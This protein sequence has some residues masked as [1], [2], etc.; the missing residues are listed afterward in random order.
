MSPRGPRRRRWIALVVGLVVAA[1]LAVLAIG[2]VLSGVLGERGTNLDYAVANEQGRY[3]LHLKT[4]DNEIIGQVMVI[5]GKAPDT[6]ATATIS[7]NADSQG[8]TAVTIGADSQGYKWSGPALDPTTTYSIEEVKD[9]NGHGLNAT[10]LPFRL[11]QIGPGQVVSN[12]H[13]TMS[14][15][16]WL[17]TKPRGIK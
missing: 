16:D 6:P 17:A 2:Y 4:C 12:A 5:E 14:L 13:G 8:S 15:E 3:V 1:P 11:E 7:K 10:I 9:A